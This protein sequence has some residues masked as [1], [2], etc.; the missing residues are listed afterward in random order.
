[1]IGQQNFQAIMAIRK[2]T[3]VQDLLMRLIQTLQ[4]DCHRRKILTH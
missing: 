4:A 3:F 2:A 1:M